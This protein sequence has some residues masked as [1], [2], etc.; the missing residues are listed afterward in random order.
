MSGKKETTQIQ[1]VNSRTGTRNVTSIG[2]VGNSS[3]RCSALGF[4]GLEWEEL[5]I[6]LFVKPSALE[7]FYREPGPR[8]ERQGIHHQLVY[9]VDLASL[10]LVVEKMNEAV[11]RLQDSRCAQ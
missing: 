4:Y 8:G 1:S 9:G 2:P 10:W 11:S 5:E 3:R 7:Y 6:I